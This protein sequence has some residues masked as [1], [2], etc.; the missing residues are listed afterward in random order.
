MTST[1]LKILAL[2]ALLTL[3]NACEND[4]LTVTNCDSFVVLSQAKYQNNPTEYYSIISA[5]ING[6]CLEIEY[7]SSGC[8]GKNW[9]EEMVDAEEILESF[10]VQRKLK[11]LLDNK[12]ACAA[13]FTKLVSFD[14]TPVQI[15]GYS[16]IILNV[17][18]YEKPLIYRYGSDSIPELIIR[19]K[20]DLINI[21]GGLIGMNT[22]FPSGS[23]TWEFDDAKVHITNNN[24][25]MNPGYD[26]FETGTYNYM[27]HDSN[28]FRTLTVDNQELGLIVIN[29]ENLSVDQRA[30]D[31]FQ[32]LFKQHK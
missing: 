24:P 20:W 1:Y 4:D 11:M 17:D 23:I 15:D 21:N 5:E 30:V 3:L 25:M 6:D 2:V 26:G 19:K 27:L 29:N 31:G 13:V 22:D 32:I 10:P 28:G 18:G 14:L 7:S 9:S 16:E 8:D 12:E